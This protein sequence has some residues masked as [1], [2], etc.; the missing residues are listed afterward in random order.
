MRCGKFSNR[1]AFSHF[2]YLLKSKSLTRKCII[3]IAMLHFSI[4]NFHSNHYTLQQISHPHAK[5]L[6]MQNISTFNWPSLLSDFN[7]NCSRSI[8]FSKITNWMKIHFL[9]FM[10]HADRQSRQQACWRFKCFGTWYSA[11]EQV[12]ADISKDHSAIISS[13]KLHSERKSTTAFQ[14]ATK[15]TAPQPQRHKS[16][17]TLMCELQTYCYC[18]AKRH[19]AKR[20]ED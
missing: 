3:N 17:A 12:V 8:N 20:Y 6:Q 2:H 7:Q 19:L 13:G 11:I 1:F 14:N 15:Y 16:W 4:W 5:C 9:F 10:L 18:E